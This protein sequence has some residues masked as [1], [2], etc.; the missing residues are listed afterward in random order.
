MCPSFEKTSSSLGAD[1]TDD[2]LKEDLVAAAAWFRFLGDGTGANTGGDS[3]G[4]SLVPTSHLVRVCHSRSQSLLGFNFQQNTDTALGIQIADAALLPSSYTLHPTN[5][6]NGCISICQF[7]HEEKSY[8]MEVM[9]YIVLQ[10]V[11]LDVA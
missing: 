7:P 4:L 11:T 10:L 3:T 1:A 9:G 2:D 6:S 8:V 5:E